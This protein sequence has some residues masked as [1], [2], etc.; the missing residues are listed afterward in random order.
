MGYLGEEF[1]KLGFGLMRLPMLDNGEVDIEQTKQM[2]DLFLSRGFTYFD[3]AYGY[4]EG[5][6]EKAVKEVLVKRYPRESFQLAT[7]LPAWAGAKNAEEAKGMFYTSL[8]RTGAGYFDFYLLHN[9]GDTRTAVFDEFGIWDFVKGLKEQ[10]L[11]RHMGFSFHDKADKLEEILKAHPE[12]EFVQLQI[13]YADWESEII[14][15]R[16]CYETARKYGK[17][18]IIMEPVKGG[19][20]AN[21]PEPAAEIFRKADPN[22]SQ[23]SWALRFAASLP[24]LVTVLSGMSTLDQMKD[25]VS[26]MENFKPLT[27]EEQAVI[28]KVQEKLASLPQIP[29]TSCQ[30]CVKGCPMGIAIPGTFKAMNNYLIYNNLTG[31]LGNYKFETRG[32]GFASKCIECGQCES[33][34]PQHIHIIDELKRAVEVLEKA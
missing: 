14:Q 10:G 6:S 26:F 32:G 3:T 16:K 30:Y 31:A 11:I 22:A 19:S 7:K 12:V 4:L 27:Q 25:N 28:A 23:S 18:V 24:G 34:C 9:L 33:V 20:L 1:K 2:V 21:L 8:E 17:P 5:K 29:C 15:S 13:N